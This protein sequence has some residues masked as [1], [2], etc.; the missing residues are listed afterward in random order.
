VQRCAMSALGHERPKGDVSV[1]SV[2]HRHA[3]D[4]LA[5]PF[6]AISRHPMKVSDDPGK[7]LTR[8]Q[9][10]VLVLPPHRSRPRRSGIS[11]TSNEIVAGQRAVQ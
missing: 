9:G 3:P 1:G 5:R 4:W 6:R 7:L 8:Q 11:A 10:Q 2:I